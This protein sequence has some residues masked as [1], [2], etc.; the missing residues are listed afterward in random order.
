MV[1]FTIAIAVLLYVMKR[2]RALLN[3]GNDAKTDNEFRISM[4]LIIVT[5]LFIL[6][7]VLDLVVY[8]I[9]I[10][11]YDKRPSDIY[12]RTLIVFPIAQ[13]LNVINHSVNFGIYFCFFKNFRET[14]L[15][16]FP[17]NSDINRNT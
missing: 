1:I 17:R 6:S 4:M 8:Q 14:A 2:K 9:L 7:R 16:C 3:E 13:L 10:H 11:F 15:A 12:N 5:A